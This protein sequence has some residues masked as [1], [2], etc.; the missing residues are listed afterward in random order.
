M[1]LEI[2]VSTRIIRVG[3]LFPRTMMPIRTLTKRITN[4]PNKSHKGDK[5]TVRA[6]IVKLII[7]M[8]AKAE[9]TVICISIA[10]EVALPGAMPRLRASSTTKVVPARFRLGKTVLRKGAEYKRKS[11]L[12]M[13]G[14]SDRLERIFV[15]KAL[16]KVFAKLSKDCNH[17]RDH[18]TLCHGG[19]QF[20]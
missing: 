6:K 1:K 7:I 12:G 18:G 9:S 17:E 4:K 16:G 14:F 19:C 3:F 8:V 5:P 11:M 15:G 2:G 13:H 20:I 10:A